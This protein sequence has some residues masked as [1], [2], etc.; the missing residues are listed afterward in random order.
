[1]RSRGEWWLNKQAGHIF[2]T[3][4]LEFVYPRGADDAF[5]VQSGL[6]FH[7]SDGAVFLSRAVV[8]AL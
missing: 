8:G 2:F 3:K 6:S 7:K 4:G 5:H 1:M